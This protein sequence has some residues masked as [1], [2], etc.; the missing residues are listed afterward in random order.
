MKRNKR[1]CALPLCALLALSLFSGCSTQTS[2]ETENTTSDAA[3][4]EST[5]AAP[6]AFL[7]INYAQVNDTG[8]DLELSIYLANGRF[9]DTFSADQISFG[10]DFESASDIELV[11]ISDENDT[12]QIQLTLE[13]RDVDPQ[14]LN[15][16]A[17]LSL[18]AGAVVDLDGNEIDDLNLEQELVY[19][20]AE[21]SSGYTSTTFANTDTVVYT[22][23]SGVTDITDFM[24][25]AYNLWEQ[26]ASNLKLIFDFSR[27]YNLSSD[28]IY[29]INL[30]I[31]RLHPSIIFIN[32]NSSSYRQLLQAA[33]ASSKTVQF[34]SGTNSFI[35]YSSASVYDDIQSLINSGKLTLDAQL[36]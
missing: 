5:A 1:I 27:S 19:N 35:N 25:P 34:V 28:T 30:M 13:N 10:Q 14:D 3:K 21:R 22:L 23:R 32:A 4:T 20:D 11:D 16:Q 17:S 26:D 9:L 7:G 36:N 6:T 31:A 18:P 24:M 29:G 8:V 2:T 12:A 15:L 33:N